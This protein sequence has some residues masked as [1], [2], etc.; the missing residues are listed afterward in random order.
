MILLLYLHYTQDSAHLPCSPLDP[1]A[2][3]EAQPASL[4]PGSRAISGALAVCFLCLEEWTR[5]GCLSAAWRPGCVVPPVL[6]ACVHGHNAAPL[7][8]Q[9]SSVYLPPA[10][11][12]LSA[13]VAQVKEGLGGVPSSVLS[14]LSG[15]WGLRSLASAEA[16]PPESWTLG[17]SVSLACPPR[18]GQA[19]ASTAPPRRPG[20]FRKGGVCGHLGCRW[21]AGHGL[22]PGQSRA[23]VLRRGPRGNRL[24]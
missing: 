3:Q 16:L 18:R 19:A 20:T 9:D 24:G 2:P 10:V 5:S 1:P 7:S 17:P 14:P 11:V 12:Y 21:P 8:G 15:L 4:T 6:T 22:V 23:G 13:P